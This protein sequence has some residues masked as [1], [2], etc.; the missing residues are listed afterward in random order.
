MKSFNRYIREQRELDINDLILEKR[1]ELESDAA[2]LT[3]LYCGSWLDRTGTYIQSLFDPHQNYALY[4]V[5]TSEVDN[6]KEKLKQNKGIN[7]FRVVRAGD[8]SYSIICF[9]YNADKD[10]KRQEA[11]A[12]EKAAEAKKAQEFEDAVK[13]A[14]TEKYG[15]DKKHID[16]MKGYFNKHSDP[17]RLVKSIKDNDKLVA[18][19]IAAMLID[20]PE[21]VSVFGYEIEQRKLL[22]KAEIVAYGEKYKNQKVDDSDMNRLDKEEKKLAESWITKSLYKWLETQSVEIEW[23]ETFK[24]A[25]T[26]GGKDIMRRTGLA[27]TEGFVIKV[28]KDGKSKNITFDIVTNEGGGLYGYC[29]GYEVVNLKK[30]KEILEREF[31]NI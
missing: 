30:F 4:G 5:R 10:E 31:N 16:K 20:W 29:I 13:N 15:T 1:S 9:Y 22:T 27:W 23:V 26:Q 6:W 3:Y 28:T 8:R 21:A 17:E 18:R 11:I 19:W 25:K 2:W 12:N 14:D 24:G 7:K